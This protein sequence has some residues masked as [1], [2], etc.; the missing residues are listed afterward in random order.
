MEER[1][2]LGE[3]AVDP[4]DSRGTLGQ[5]VVTEAASA[6]HLDEQAAEL[7]D[8]FRARRQERAPLAPEQSGVRP[9]WGYSLGVWRASAEERRHARE[10]S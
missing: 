10:S 7:A 8:R 9:T 6:V 2:D 1:L 4:D 3:A 5:Q